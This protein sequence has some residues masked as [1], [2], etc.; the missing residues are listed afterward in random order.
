MII[1][2]ASRSSSTHSIRLE[3]SV[4]HQDCKTHVIATR[5]IRSRKQHACQLSCLRGVRPYYRTL[6]SVQVKRPS[7]YYVFT[8]DIM[9]IPNIEKAT[10]GPQTAAEGES[11]PFRPNWSNVL[12][13]PMKSSHNATAYPTVATF[14]FRFSE[15]ANGAVNNAIMKGRTS[16]E[17]RFSSATLK[18]RLSISDS[19]DSIRERISLVER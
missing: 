1:S 18:L 5:V 12:V 13:I 19:L 15:R 17:Y 16:V 4:I 3:G 10:K 6:C 8:R 7:I 2:R 9:K 14:P 11:W